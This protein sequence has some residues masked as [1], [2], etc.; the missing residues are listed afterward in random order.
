MSRGDP[1]PPLGVLIDA[2]YHGVNR[3]IAERLEAEGFAN[4]RAA[5]GKVFEHLESG[6]SVSELA[7]R[8][9]ITKQGMAELVQHLERHGYVARA[10][11]PADG[12]ATVVR[13]TPRGRRAVAAAERILDE[14]YAEWGRIIGADRLAQLHR[15]LG[16]LVGS[17]ATTPR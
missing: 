2:L 4:I 7:E 5:H 16:K 13:L 11:D 15:S 3:R 9:Q 8:A 12:R 10:P 1:L 17:E 14:I 6:R